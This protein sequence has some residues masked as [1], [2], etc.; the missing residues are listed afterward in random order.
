MTEYVPA[1]HL[2]EIV[3]ILRDGD[4]EARLDAVRQLQQRARRS[5]RAEGDAGCA[6]RCHG[7]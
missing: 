2:A 3:S 7:R 4:E 1:S 6:D 5:R